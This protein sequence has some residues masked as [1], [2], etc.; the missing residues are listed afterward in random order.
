M[1][2]ASSLL[3]DSTLLAGNIASANMLELVRGVM[4]SS[5]KEELS[6]DLNVRV[7]DTPVKATDTFR[8][9]DILVKF[10]AAFKSQWLPSAS[11]AFNNPVVQVYRNLER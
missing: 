11:T 4:K 5:Q 2:H 9:D 8:K 3:V 6:V 7:L 10:D 1:F